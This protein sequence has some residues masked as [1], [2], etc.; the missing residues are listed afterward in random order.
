M[1][2]YIQITHKKRKK[3]CEDY[4]SINNNEKGYWFKENLCLKEKKKVES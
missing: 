4:K 1:I 3:I 2:T